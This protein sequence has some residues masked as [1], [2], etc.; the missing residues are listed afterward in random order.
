VVEGDVP[1]AHLRRV[2]TGPACPF[3]DAR[4]VGATAD[5]IDIELDARRLQPLH[6]LVA[7]GTAILHEDGDSVGA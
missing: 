1:C 7:G 2:D 5:D 3:T 4:V 6:G